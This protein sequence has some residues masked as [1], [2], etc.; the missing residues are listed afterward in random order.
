[1]E[2]TNCI[3]VKRAVMVYICLVFI[4]VYTLYTSIYV[5]FKVYRITFLKQDQL[6]CKLVFPKG[7]G[8]MYATAKDA[9]VVIIV[10]VG[11]LVSIYQL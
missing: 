11:F 5:C 8:V 4:G 9:L 7:E 10:L 2:C 6:R 3:C 1:L